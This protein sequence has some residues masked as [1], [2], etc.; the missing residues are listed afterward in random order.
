MYR[1]FLNKLMYYLIPNINKYIVD[2]TVSHMIHMIRGYRFK[3]KIYLLYATT[4][5]SA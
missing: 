1:W 2:L 5:F 4:I 3:K